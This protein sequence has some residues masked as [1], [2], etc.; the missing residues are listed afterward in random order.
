MS[1]K[2]LVFGMTDKLG[3]IETFLMNYCRVLRE[4]EI[5]FDFLCNTDVV[6]RECEIH[7]L[8]GNIYHIPMRSEDP[9]YFKSALRRFF[10][11]HRNEYDVFWQ[12]V[13]SLANVDYLI[14]AKRIGIPMRIIHCHNGNEVG[15]QLR[16]MLHRLNRKRVLKYATDFWT[17]SDNAA[18]WFFGSQIM[19]LP[20]YRM[21]PNAIDVTKLRF[22]CKI[23]QSIRTR[24]GWSD[25]YIIGN[26]G[27]LEKQKNHDLQL[28]ILQELVKRDDRYHLVLIG[29]GSRRMEIEERAKSLG[30]IDHV[31]FFGEADDI[32]SLYQ[33]MDLFL[34]PSLYEGMPIALLEAQANCLPCVISDSIPADA[35]LNHNVIPCALNASPDAWA[36]SIEDNVGKR[37]TNY[38]NHLTGSVYDLSARSGTIEEA[39][40]NRLSVIEQY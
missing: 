33:A 5:L 29:K 34:F 11:E 35:S 9:F 28:L 2:V 24:Y 12:N 1:I 23:R 26:V 37:C 21:I 19:S 31:S 18:Q 38:M 39:I 30:L 7:E 32:S 27:R 14:E 22:D 13:N 10:D 15:S 17:C 25:D 40:I 8:G 20:T 36:D 3:G 6:A 16:L 4:R